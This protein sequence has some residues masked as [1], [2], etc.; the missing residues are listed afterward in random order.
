MVFFLAF[1]AGGLVINWVFMMGGGL[2]CRVVE[3]IVVIAWETEGME[4]VHAVDAVGACGGVI[5]RGN[6][7]HC[8]VIHFYTVLSYIKV[9]YISS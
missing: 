5:W 2:G 9:S 7:Y 6:H 8:W 1:L 4:P 3:A